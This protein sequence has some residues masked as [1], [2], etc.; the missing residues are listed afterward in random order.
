MF[1]QV[2]TWVK[3]LQRVLGDS[4]ALMIVGNKLDLEKER[5]V[6]EQEAR[7]LFKFK[8]YFSNW[9]NFFSFF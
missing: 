2:K 1:F 3:E 4:C 9:D 7:R 5:T 8:N 6:T